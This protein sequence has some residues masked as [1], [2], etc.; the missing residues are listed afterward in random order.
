MSDAL[1]RI[2]SSGV[3]LDE[4]R[5]FLD[6]GL[7]LED[8]EAAVGRMQA[9]GEKIG[10]EE[11]ENG[12]VRPDDFSDVGNME[13]FSTLNARRLLYTDSRGWL[14]WDELRW[15]ADDH[16]AH[17]RA[18]LFSKAMLDDA[19]GRYKT[20]LHAQARGKGPGGRRVLGAVHGSG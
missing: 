18:V 8:V 15:V 5:G 7:S 2:L 4:V 17:E 19:R 3:S 11:E 16:Q 6:R 14:C 1:S 13:T 12:E 9:R 20:A 10:G